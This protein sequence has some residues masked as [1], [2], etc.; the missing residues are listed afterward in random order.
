MNLHTCI[1]FWKT[2]TNRELRIFECV[3]DSDD[4]AVRKFNVK[5]GIVGGVIQSGTALILR[6]LR[7]GYSGIT[8]Y[9]EEVAVTDF[10]GVPIKDGEQV[11]GILVADR[12]DNREFTDSEKDIFY[13]SVESILQNLYNERVF[14]QLQTAKSEQSKLLRASDALN[15]ALNE[16]DV[17]SAAIRAISMIAPFDIAAIAIINDENLQEIKLFQVRNRICWKV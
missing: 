14:V 6:N 9:A 11:K 3:S 4:I 5:E 17:I 13:L 16:K 8:Y 1:V 12:I 10:I 7:P 15:K 2:D